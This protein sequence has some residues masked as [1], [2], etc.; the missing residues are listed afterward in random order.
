MI[1]EIYINLSDV[2][3]KEELFEIFGSNFLFP[4]YFWGNWDA[5]FDVMQSSELQERM[6]K[7]NAITGICL[8]LDGFKKFSKNFP[9]E[10]QEIFLS[11]LD[12]IST[13]KLPEENNSF[14]FEIRYLS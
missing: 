12:E 3:K 1:Y 2:R 4:S 10:E 8:V 13:L 9:P 11:I 7:N 14:T 5:F 6:N